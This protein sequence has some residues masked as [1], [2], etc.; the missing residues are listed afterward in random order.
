MRGDDG[1][2]AE[3]HDVGGRRFQILRELAESWYR[4]PGNLVSFDRWNGTWKAMIPARRCGY[5]ST[6]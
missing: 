3:V 5:A 2:L 4:S 1:Q 6:R